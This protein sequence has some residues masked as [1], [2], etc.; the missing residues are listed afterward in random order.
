MRLS[1]LLV[2]SG[3][4]TAAYAQQKPILL[5]ATDYKGSGVILEATN[6]TNIPYTVVL[7][8]TLQNMEPSAVLP[9]RKVIEPTGKKTTLTRLTP[10][11]QPYRYTYNYRYYLGNTL[12]VA[13]TAGYVYDLPFEAGQEYEVMQGNN[14]AFSHVNKLAVDFS[15]PEGSVVCAARA[16][17]VAEIKQDSNTGCPTA[18]CKDFGNY[19]IIFHEDG[20]YATYV[21]FRQNGS[22]VQPG[23]QVTAGTPIGYSGNTGWSSG[24]HLH[25][26]VDMPSEQEKI[27][28]PVKFRAGTQ[29]LGE[30]QQGT[31]YRR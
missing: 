1:S 29:I 17:T 23:Q 31:R 16:G 2:L 14:G 22:L 15:M 27:T 28:L 11:G 24:P 7:T 19:I 12:A 30:L 6:T 8:C 26:E 10:V 4:S 25:F 21:H 5:T 9:L 20:T 18:S 13:P 3:I